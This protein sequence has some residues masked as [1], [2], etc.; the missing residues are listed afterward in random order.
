MLNHGA[1][2]AEVLTASGGVAAMAILPAVF[3]LAGPQAGQA[4]GI[5]QRQVV[6]PSSTSRS[7]ASKNTSRPAGSV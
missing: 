1:G 2:G 7:T 3:A 6:L 5:G 4:L